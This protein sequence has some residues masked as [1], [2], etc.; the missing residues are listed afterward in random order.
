[1]DRHAVPA[2]TVIEALLFKTPLFVGDYQGNSILDASNAELVL[3]TPFSMTVYQ[4]QFVSRDGPPQEVRY[5]FPSFISVE[6]DDLDVPRVW[7]PEEYLSFSI[8]IR[9]MGPRGPRSCR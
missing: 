2:K 8:D 4:E 1:V 7:F 5:P 3:G 6:P 9:W